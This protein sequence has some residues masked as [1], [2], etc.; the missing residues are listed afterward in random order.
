MDEIDF[1]GPKK[2][3]RYWADFA[4][5]F[6]HFS[7]VIAIPVT[8]PGNHWG[9]TPGVILIIMQ[10]LTIFFHFQYVFLFVESPLAINFFKFHS[11]EE[12][13]AESPNVL[14]WL[15]Y[16]A[17]ATLGTLALYTSS[18]AEY[19]PDIVFLLISLAISEQTVGFM[20]DEDFKNTPI[21]LQFVQWLSASLGQIAE[22]TVVG[23]AIYASKDPNLGGFW[24]YVVCWSLF[25]I[26]ALRNMVRRYNEDDN[27]TTA[28]F[29]YSLLSTISKSLVFIFTGLHL[30]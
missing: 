25:G 8:N 14:K 11:P 16:S 30:S 23:R 26:W 17:S 1:V 6:V 27:I 7:L 4:A 21:R 29:G 2:D 12:G 19:N 22:F 5:I 15:E 20:L 28:E 10:L 24:S 18:D 9:S 3:R 13:F